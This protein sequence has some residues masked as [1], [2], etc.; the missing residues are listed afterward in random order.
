MRARARTSRLA[1]SRCAAALDALDPAYKR[2]LYP[3]SYVVGMEAGLAA[4][5][6]DLVRE[7]MAEASV[8]LPWKAPR[9]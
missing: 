6:D 3:Q 8:S 4:V 7:R 9:A 5:R 1:R 2:F